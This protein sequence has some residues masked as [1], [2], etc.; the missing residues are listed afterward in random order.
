MRIT[1][2]LLVTG[3]GL[4]SPAYATT[5][6]LMGATGSAG[7]DGADGHGFLP[8]AGNGGDGE[9]L[10]QTLAASDAINTLALTGGNGGAGGNGGDATYDLPNNPFAFGGNGGNGGAGGAASSTVS[11]TTTTDSTLASSSAF[12]GTGGSGGLGGT[13]QDSPGAPGKS[14]AG[15]SADA[16]STAF[17]GSST[18]AAEAY[19][20]GGA[21]AGAG[22][23]HSVA[24]A[25]AGSS[26]ARAA[27]TS[28]G[29][30]GSL[31]GEAGANAVSDATASSG[32]FGSALA[33]ARATGGKAARTAVD[34]V[35][36][37]PGTATAT[38]HATSVSGNATAEAEQVGGDGAPG[39]QGPLVSSPLLPGGAGQSSILN[40]AV[41][42][43]TLGLLTLRQ[44]ADGGNGGPNAMGGPAMST[45][46]A[47]NP[48]GGA[49]DVQVVA[50]AGSSGGSF[51][52]TAFYTPPGS[53]ATA[54]A[55]AT[56]S[57]GASASAAA[58]AY[59]GA[60]GVAYYQG[61]MGTGGTA[62]SNAHAAGLGT[63]KAQAES[64]TRTGGMG[65]AAADAARVGSSVSAH[66]ST[67]L[68]SGSAGFY[69]M[70]V[71]RRVGAL[72]GVGAPVPPGPFLAPI[73]ETSGGSLLALPALADAERWRAGNPN[74]LAAGGKVL[75]LGSLF[76]GVGSWAPD[77]TGS[78][79]LDLTTADVG[80]SP[81]L[82][83]AFLDPL[84]FG[85]SLEL[86]HLSFASDGVTVLDTTFTDTGSAIAGL[87]DFVIHVGRL[88]G[89]SNLVHRLV[90]SFELEFLAPTGPF[91][92][93]AQQGF[94]LNFA[95][96]PEPAAA[97]SILVAA[98][99]L[100]VHR[101]R[102]G[103]RSRRPRGPRSCAA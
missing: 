101:I 33:T 68:P 86:L 1:G 26:G 58:Q 15:G 3:L 98:N 62:T 8:P 90:L 36:G 9:S 100:L 73:S 71:Q 41:S 55:R 42:G 11:T 70:S 69:M 20:Q 82:S 53:P 81:D 84:A 49:L 83:L 32:G 29:G 79:E 67:S 59:G 77:L 88:G 50:V 72:A 93:S 44:V 74:A 30:N 4:T 103:R 60:A 63:A 76:N 34:G 56:D 16:S 80:Y 22:A 46:D 40:N 95:L 87:D 92:V 91:E 78:I 37:T 47:T 64:V 65:I 99:L 27:A 54:I 52:Q 14:G 48:G 23:A 57:T 94:G 96:V 39:F 2:V 89:P 75:A 21:G 35:F 61:V 5:I 17:S 102:T 25:A 38:A 43:S 19:S 28:Y 31:G 6:V 12:G 24:N 66:V 85:A 18:S 7:A 10:S 13:G 51:D 97:V 45:L